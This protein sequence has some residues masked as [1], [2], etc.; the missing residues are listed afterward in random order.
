MQRRLA[1]ND[2]SLVF[3]INYV[4]RDFLARGIINQELTSWLLLTESN[5][6]V[7]CI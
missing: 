4:H 2:N 1:K 5:R 6:K 3:A 7:Y